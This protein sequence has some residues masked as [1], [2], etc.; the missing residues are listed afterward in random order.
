MKS[1]M[2]ALVVGLVSIAQVQ[3]APVICKRVG[4]ILAAAD[5]AISKRDQ[6]NST[7][8][9]YVGTTR[10]GK[11]KW[12]VTVGV[13]EECLTGVIVYTKAGTCKVTDAMEV[14]NRDC[15]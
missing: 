14:G 11:D 5:Q 12:M 8:A 4:V 3:A 6:P 10:T 13:Q 1:Q 15:G 9:V 2:L 7:D